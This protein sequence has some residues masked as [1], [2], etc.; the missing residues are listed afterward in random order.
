MT[1]TLARAADAVAVLMWETATLSVGALAAGCYWTAASSKGKQ[2]SL[3]RKVT[4]LHSPWRQTQCPRRSALEVDSRKVFAQFRL[5]IETFPEC[6]ALAFHRHQN[7]PDGSYC[8]G[9]ECHVGAVPQLA[10]P[11]IPPRIANVVI[12]LVPAPALTISSKAQDSL[13]T[14]FSYKDS[15]PL[16]QFSWSRLMNHRDCS[17]P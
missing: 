3:P 7:H 8:Q 2:R 13:R 14:P 4:A 6:R 15:W 17:G 12:S 1:D 10:L 11:R 16:R 5:R 9:G